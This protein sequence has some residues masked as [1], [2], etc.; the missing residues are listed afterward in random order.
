MILVDEAGAPLEGATVTGNW[1]LNGNSI[2][3]GVS[4]TTNDQGQA[5]INSGRVNANS[6]ELFIFTVTDVSKAG[7]TWDGVQKSGSAQVP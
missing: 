5:R 7:L 4:G 2:K 3:T 6:G 1:D